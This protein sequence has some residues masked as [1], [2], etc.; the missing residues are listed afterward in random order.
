MGTQSS[1]V[2]GLRPA[3]VLGLSM[4]AGALAAMAAQRHT[5]GAANERLECP[6]KR[7][8][9]Q[10]QA[11]PA[12]QRHRHRELRGKAVDDPELAEVLA[13]FEERRVSRGAGPE[14]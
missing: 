14:R 8:G 11:D 6:E 2:R 1:G 13:V 9:G 12:M 5:V 3:A 10:R 7:A 4:T